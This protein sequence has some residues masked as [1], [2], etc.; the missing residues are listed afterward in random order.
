MVAVLE[1]QITIGQPAKRMRWGTFE[2]T[3]SK[4]KLEKTASSGRGGER[5]SKRIRVFTENAC[6]PTR[7]FRGCQER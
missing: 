2:S 6:N 5:D 7:N 3:A 4:E 1:P